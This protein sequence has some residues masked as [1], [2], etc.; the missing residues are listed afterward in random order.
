MPRRGLTLLLAGLAMFGPFA[1]DT[2]FPAFPAI[3]REFG[4]DEFAMQPNHVI[5]SVADLPRLLDLPQ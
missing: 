4:A 1:I 3:A 2:M 5:D